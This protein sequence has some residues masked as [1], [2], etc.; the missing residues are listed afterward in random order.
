MTGHLLALRSVCAGYRERPVLHD[1]SLEVRAGEVV[2]LLGSNG[3]GKTTTLLTVSGMTQRSGGTIELLGHSTEQPGRRRDPWRSGWRPARW[4]LGHVPDDRGLFAELTVT[5]HL[6]LAGSARR[7]TRSATADPA[8]VANWFPA[9]APL[10]KRRA[11]LLSGGEQQMLALA[12]ALSAGP[13]LLLIDELSTG[14]APMIVEHL[15][16]VLRSIASETGL[17]VLVVE[18]HVQTVLEV[19]DR[20]Y[21]LRRGRVVLEG[22]AESLAAQPDLLEAGYLDA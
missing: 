11:G 18:Q 10:A 15:L 2:A 7:S 8:R 14:L 3:A 19:A 6:R 5:E 17:G 20:G 13:K 1:V 21:V 16:G 4:G 12:T 9:L 22:T